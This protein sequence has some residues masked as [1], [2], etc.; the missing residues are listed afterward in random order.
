M[1]SLT[2]SVDWTRHRLIFVQNGSTDPKSHEYSQ[3]VVEAINDNFWGRAEHIN[4][5]DNLG[6]ARGLNVGWQK[7]LPGEHVVKA[8]SDIVWHCPNWCDRLEEIV[9]RWKRLAFMKRP[10][11]KARG[12]DIVLDYRRP[13]GMIGLKR[14][15]LGE[16]TYRKDWGESRVLEV[17]QQPGEYWL[18]FE[19]C[20][21]VVGSCVLHTSDM[22]D[23]LG[24]LYQGPLKY[25]LDDSIMCSRARAA[26]YV[27][28]FHCS[29]DIEHIDPGD[30][31]YQTWKQKHAGEKY[32]WARNRMEAYE[33]HE[34]PV[35]QGP[36]DE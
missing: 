33:A 22:L 23:E 30:T 5:P 29:A 12:A 20:K 13:I 16:S 36:N 14:R 3:A 8:D 1:E 2:N 18:Y 21:H 28:G 10:H 34:I 27:N 15:D 6:T 7:R 31:P 25:G 11:P 24:Y 9:E 4:L 35:W 32:D 17:P 19:A 26:G